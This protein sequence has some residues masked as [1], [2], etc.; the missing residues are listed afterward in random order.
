M[1]SSI[2]GLP[3]VYGVNNNIPQQNCSSNRNWSDLIIIMATGVRKT[4]RVRSI[5][6]QLYATIAIAPGL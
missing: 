3:A 1:I 6:C 4:N 2:A 5:P